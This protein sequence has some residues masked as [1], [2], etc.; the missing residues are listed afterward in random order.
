MATLVQR[1][2]GS[3]TESQGTYAKYDSSEVDFSSPESPKAGSV[4][5]DDGG[6]QPCQFELLAQP[7]A[8]L[9]STNNGLTVPTGVPVST[10]VNCLP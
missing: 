3:N 2:M 9:I 5:E 4:V 10:A 6:P 8:E 7:H 1:K